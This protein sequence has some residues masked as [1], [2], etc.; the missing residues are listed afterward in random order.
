MNR[1]SSTPKGPIPAKI[2]LGFLRSSMMPERRDWNAMG[3]PM[4]G[5]FRA[6]LR[7]IDPT[8]VLQFV[9]PRSH[10]EG[11]CDPSRNP[12]GVWAIC[13]RMPNTGWL[14]KRWVY[15]MAKADG[16]WLPPTRDLVELLIK[17]RNNW[18][19]G[20]LDDMEATF[21]RHVAIK[22]KEAVAQSK[23]RLHQR[24]D[25]R[26]RAANMREFYNRRVVVPGGMPA[27]MVL[28]CG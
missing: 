1:F 7:K 3:P 12:F 4:P 28:P 25:N 14:C 18:R 13:R 27:G 19:R 15:S 20:R 9:P 16:T 17:A 11:G 23:E 8:L 26:M 6:Y 21:D 2:L 22:R 5:W 24:I 10:A